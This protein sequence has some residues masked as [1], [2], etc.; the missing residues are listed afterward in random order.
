MS[1]YDDNPTFFKK[2]SELVRSKDGL[3]GT[4]EWNEF[5]TMLPEF[6]GKRV[7]DLGCGYGWHCKYA[8]EN[9]AKSVTGV[10]ISVKMIEEAKKKNSD[11]H[12]E[13]YV[14]RMQ[15]VDFPAD[16]FDVVVSSLAF[17]YVESFD[18]ICKMVKKSL[19][20]GGDFVF[21][22]NH[23]IF[24]SYGTCDWYE[25]E[26]GERVHWPIDRYFE[27]GIRKTNFLG[28]DVVMYHRTVS[29]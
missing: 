1:E 4:G 20:S 29:T 26:K 23:P 7:L 12:I 17:Q 16:S 3:K 5:R 8:S 10:D 21:L 24:T 22:I 2:Y 15:D 27:E 18:K 6:H 28:E 13:Y 9:G 25:N 14:K 11:P 19:V